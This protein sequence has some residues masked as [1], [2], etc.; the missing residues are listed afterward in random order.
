MAR[1]LIVRAL[2]ATAALLQCFAV[3]RAECDETI[4]FDVAVPATSISADGDFGT[5]PIP[6][7]DP[8]LGALCKVELSFDAEFGATMGYE[9]LNPNGGVPFG[10]MLTW[11]VDLLDVDMSSLV[12]AEATRSVVGFV[13]AYD[14]TTDYDGPSGQSFDV[15]SSDS[16]SGAT[17]SG[18]NLTWFTNAGTLNL[19]FHAMYDL[20]V[21]GPGLLPAN[22]SADAFDVQF[23][24]DLTVTYTFPEPT[25]LS[26]VLLG[27]GLLRRRR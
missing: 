27:A 2:F 15:V 1:Y 14:G 26:M 5:I 16:G 17:M 10:M 11:T 19:P 12:N 23:S 22:Y 9:N 6:G 20:E 24:G 13:D 7:F 3:A 21:F 4:S 25:T 8:S 18:S